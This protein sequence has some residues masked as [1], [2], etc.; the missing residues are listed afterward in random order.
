MLCTVCT[1]LIWEGGLISICG[2]NA[3]KQLALIPHLP[4]PPSSLMSAVSEY[5]EVER[6]FTSEPEREIF[7]FYFC[8]SEN[9]KEWDKKYGKS[10]YKEPENKK[11]GVWLCQFEKPVKLQSW[12]SADISK[13]YMPKMT[14]KVVFVIGI[15][16]LLILLC[17]IIGKNLYSS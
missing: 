10:G 7:S 5:S 13:S 15:N 12:N 4:T 1:A 3:G 9:K 11:T 16:Y 17:R 2:Q 8:K 6:N 14:I